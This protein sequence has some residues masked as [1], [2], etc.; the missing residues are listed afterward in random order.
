M[1]S[2]RTEIPPAPI[3]ALVVL[4]MGVLVIAPGALSGAVADAVMPLRFAVPEVALLAPA[5]I[6][7][8]AVLAVWA[9]ARAPRTGADRIVATIALAAVPVAYLSSETLKSAFAEERP[10]QAAAV[11]AGCPGAG[12][13]SF[14]SN[15]STV[16]FALA[17]SVAL[18]VSGW[19]AVTSAVLAVVAASGRVL[20]GVHYPHD[21]AAGALVGIACVVL[22]TRVAAA[23]ARRWVGRLAERHRRRKA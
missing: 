17:A 21:V 11:A 16:A 12:D 19:V 14:P 13:W 20:E 22:A 18:V 1:A 7:A 5:A 8:L 10:C 9:F 4:A 15:H 6:A 23:P 2:R 3:L